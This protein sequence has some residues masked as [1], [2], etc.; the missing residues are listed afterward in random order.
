[1]NT[2]DGYKSGIMFSY[3]HLLYLE[4]KLLKKFTENTMICFNNQLKSINRYGYIKLPI[5]ILNNDLESIN[6][7]QAHYEWLDFDRT[8][9]E[10]NRLFK[11]L[12]LEK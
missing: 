3:L 5:S 2:I 10:Y 1:M 9:N 6:Y 8:V 4:K 11:E 7:I 12:G